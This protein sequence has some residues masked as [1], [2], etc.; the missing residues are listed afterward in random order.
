MAVGAQFFRLNFRMGFCITYKYY[1]IMKK[2]V[3][4]SQF[5]INHLSHLNVSLVSDL[6]TLVL[7]LN[8]TIKLCGALIW[9]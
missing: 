9:T 7:E 6:E 1:E 5:Y 4:V 3:H 8:L 2:P